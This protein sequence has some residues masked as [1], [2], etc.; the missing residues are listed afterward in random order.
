MII[1]GL[2][3]NFHI[4]EIHVSPLPHP[5]SWQK[6]EKISTALFHVQTSPIFAGYIM[7]LKPACG[8]MTAAAK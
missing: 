2:S 4:L 3:D 8:R 1:V 5:P 6:H 7:I